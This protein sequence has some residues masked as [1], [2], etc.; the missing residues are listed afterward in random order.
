MLILLDLI[1]MVQTENSLLP[2]KYR[3]LCQG[4]V[5]CVVELRHLLSVII[6]LL[7][8]SNSI[9]L[10]VVLRT[11]SILVFFNR[12]RCRPKDTKHEHIIKRYHDFLKEFIRS[13]SVA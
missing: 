8:M 13:N 3:K 11:N 9:Q 10:N 1:S 7:Q 2:F 12:Q 6:T 4:T 5:L